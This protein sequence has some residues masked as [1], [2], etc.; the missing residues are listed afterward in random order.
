MFRLDF[1]KFNSKFVFWLEPYPKKDFLSVWKQKSFKKYVVVRR[2][3][4]T[5]SV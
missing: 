2:V 4:W 1:L 3:K 5:I